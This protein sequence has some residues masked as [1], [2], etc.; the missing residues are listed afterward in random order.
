MTKLQLAKAGMIL[1]ELLGS[2]LVALGLYM[3][4][5]PLALIAVGALFI[6]WARH[7]VALFLR[8]GNG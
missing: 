3:I 5:A 1:L 7:L 6:I 2:A 4:Y 8:K